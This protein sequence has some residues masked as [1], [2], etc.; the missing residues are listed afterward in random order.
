MEKEAFFSGYCRQID[1]SRMVAAV[2]EDNVLT[3][4]DCC[5]ESCI[6]AGSCTV[7][8]KLREFINQSA[9]I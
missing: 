2:A 6:Y 3:E 5:F 9:L 1:E 8:E 7:A 4:C